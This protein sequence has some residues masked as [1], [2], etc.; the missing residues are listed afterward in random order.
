MRDDIDALSRSI[1]AIINTHNINGNF[2]SMLETSIGGFLVF[3]S[4]DEFDGK[5]DA[6]NAILTTMSIALK[7]ILAD[8]PETDSCAAPSVN[9]C[10]FCG[11]TPPAVR[12]GAG[13][14]VFICNEC[15]ETFSKIL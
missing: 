15:V 3:K 6:E 9:G 2:K 4:M 11:R 5:E 8:G 12:L 14:G 10:S 7:K 1:S 13:P